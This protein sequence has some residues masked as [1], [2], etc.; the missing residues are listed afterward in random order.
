MFGI[1]PFFLVSL[2]LLG[3]FTG[4]LAGLLGIGGGMLMVPFMTMLFTAQQFALQ[5]IVHMA[6]ATSLATILFTSVS[7]IRAHHARGAVRWDIV[8]WLAPL[9]FL[10][11]VVGAQFASQ[12]KTPWLA[13]FFGLFVGY[14]ALQMLSSKKV[15]ANKTMPS[16]GTV[17]GVGG[18]IGFM[19]S[20]VGAGG[21]FITVPF[22]S[23]RNIP[24]H[25]AVASSAAM[26]FPI[27]LG[28]LLGY[29]VAGLSVQ[30]LPSGAWG[31]IYAPALLGCAVTSVLF[32]PLGAKTAHKLPVTQLK[33]I[34]AFLL[35]ALAAYMLY[36]AYVTFGL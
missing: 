23:S 25:Q 33:I 22:L 9:A 3:C 6:V 35:I 28:G 36:K 16:N 32:A 31:Y 12:L 21:G 14:S 7:S 15:A 30:G 13:L 1:D 8:R 20:L 34:F 11:T 27:A 24:L 19:S 5:H 2:L 10:G 26:G 4:F 18:L 17:L 29:I